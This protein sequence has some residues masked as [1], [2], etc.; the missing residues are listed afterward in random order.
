M[1]ALQAGFY[2]GSRIQVKY[3]GQRVEVAA[4]QE[5]PGFAETTLS[6]FVFRLDIYPRVLLDGLVKRG[7]KVDWSL[8]IAVLLLRAAEV[9]DR[10]TIIWANA[11][12]LVTQLFND[13]P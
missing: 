3:P 13:I 10:I 5:S 9:M 12:R 2:I 7:L 11:V 8:V 4:S 6:L 1:G